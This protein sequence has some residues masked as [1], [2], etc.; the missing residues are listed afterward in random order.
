MRRSIIPI[1]FAFLTLFPILLTS[2]SSLTC[3]QNVPIGGIEKCGPLS[4]NAVLNIPL[5]SA[6]VFDKAQPDLFVRTGRFGHET[7]LFLFPWLDT[8]ASGAP[9]FGEAIAIKYPFEGKHPPAGTV[10]Q[11]NDK[12]YAFWLKDGQIIHTEFNKA[13]YEFT[14]ISSLKLPPL[15]Y[16]ARNLAILPNPDGAIQIILEIPDGAKGRSD[17]FSSRD[18]RYRPY[19]GAGIWL[20]GLPYVSLYAVTLPDLFSG[21]T[22]TPRFVSAT[23]REVLNSFHQLSIVNLGPE[24]NRDLITG[25]RFGGLHYYHNSSQSAVLLKPKMHVV[26]SNENAHRHPTIEPSP[27]AYPDPGTGLSNLIVGGEGALY[28]YEFSGRF[29]KAGKPIYENPCFVQ[30]RNADIYAGTLPVPN[31]VDWD[32]DGDEDII[33]GNSEGRILYFENAGTNGSPDY[34]PA[35]PLKANGQEI[36]IQ[37]GYRGDIQGPF[38]ARWGYVCPTVADW[39]GDG[40][41]DI[42]MSDATARHTVYLNIGIKNNPVLAAGRPLYM[43]GLDLHGT[44]RVKPAVARLGEK[45]AYVA[46][47]DDDQFHLYWQIDDYNMADGGKLTLQDG[48]SIGANF[49]HSGGTGRLKLNLTDWDLDGLPDLLVGTPRHGS[50]PNPETGLPQSLGLPGSAILFLRNAGSLEKPIFA[51]PEILKFKGE[52]IFL[53]Q[54]ACA[55]TLAYFSEAGPDLIVGEEG[56]RLLYFKREDLSPK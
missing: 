46:L 16:A 43:D 56:G 47:D 54:H 11:I 38:E 2:Q 52:P 24:R 15:P 1:V 53:G 41:P 12:I 48:T 36:H 14:Q 32:Q 40:L 37:P 51:F 21:P 33:C 55:P 5:G 26:D 50:V 44:W 45:M 8:D 23:Q 42:L 7:G 29:T 13:E 39:N 6:Y 18:P 9:V 35:I 31:V 22:S 10:V 49:L 20:G 30:Q 17:E 27:I 4:T 25:S 34:L 3:G 28:F 19:D